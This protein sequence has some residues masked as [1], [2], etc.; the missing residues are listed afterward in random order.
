V[1]AIAATNVQHSNIVD[2]R[3]LRLV[4]LH[5]LPEDTCAEFSPLTHAIV[6]ARTPEGVV[7][8]RSRETYVWELP[9]GL[10]EAGETALMC[11]M[12]E[13]V[14]ETGQQPPLLH[15]CG[16][17]ELKGTPDRRHP[18][19]YVEFGALY[20]ADIE[21]LE[22]PRHQTTEIEEVA[23]WPITSLP[24]RTSMIDAEILS[25]FE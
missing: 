23:V 24:D 19:P 20:R 13:L 15:W 2:A 9:G 14:E 7:L 25:L 16:L 8:V 21:Q 3:G 1:R 18:L 17:T 12:R 4:R 11:A 6:F 10:I 5:D 22:R